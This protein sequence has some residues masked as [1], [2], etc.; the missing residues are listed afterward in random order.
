[1]SM[2]EKI[3]ETYPEHDELVFLHGFDDA[4]LGTALSQGNTVVC[5]SVKVMIDTL[6]KNDD[7]TESE[8]L[9]WLDHNTFFAYFGEHSPVYIE[10]YK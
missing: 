5:Y 6:I 9:D 4:I 7:I 1:M 10:D 8:A 2:R 3:L